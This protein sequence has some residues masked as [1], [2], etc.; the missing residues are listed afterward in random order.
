PDLLFTATAANYRDVKSL[1]EFAERRRLV[2]IV[3]PIFDVN[4]SEETLS[5]SQLLELVDLCK[6]PFVYLNG[7]VLKL[8]LAGG[9]DR[10]NP[11][12]HAVSSSLVISVEDTLLLPCFHHAESALPIQGN[13]LEV[14]SHPERQ[15]ALRQ[16]GRRPF[17]QGCTIN[18]YLAPSLPYQ[19]D[20]Y[21]FS[22]LPWAAKYLYYRSQHKLYRK[23]AA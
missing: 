16:E 5:Q 10:E 18:C 7:G 8:L 4:G 11:R 3:N 6:R 21:F 15:S 14:L 22:F 13:L 9:N 2:L 17:C 23:S 1:A 19:M 20:R 12:C